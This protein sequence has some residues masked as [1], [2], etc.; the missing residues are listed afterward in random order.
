MRKHMCSL[1]NATRACRPQV[2]SYYLQ[3]TQFV[4]KSG[5]HSQVNVNGRE[6]R[7]KYIRSKAVHVRENETNRLMRRLIL[8]V[9]RVDPEYFDPFPIIKIALSIRKRALEELIDLEGVSSQD[10]GVFKCQI[11]TSAESIRSPT[12]PNHFLISSH[13]TSPESFSSKHSNAASSSCSVS[14]S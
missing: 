13:F 6:G 14:K 4:S 2:A 12:S 11:H 10:V 7:Y 5:I 3:N 9:V 1:G 8:I